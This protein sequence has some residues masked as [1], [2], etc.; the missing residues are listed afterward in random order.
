MYLIIDNYDSFTYS[1]LPLL[2][3]DKKFIFIAVSV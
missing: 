3:R 1:Y 2:Y